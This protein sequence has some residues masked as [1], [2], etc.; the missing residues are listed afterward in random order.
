[1]AIINRIAAY[2]EDMR[3]WRHDIHR[4][5]ELAYEEHRTA[6]RVAELLREFGVDEVA[7]GIGKTG[8]VGVIRN[9]EG[10]AIGLRADMDA[11]PI[12][13]RTGV[14]HQSVND[15]VMR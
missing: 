10:P 1:M 2:V 6:G 11:L 15:G 3:A 8:V 14:P 9:G 7:E 5:P 4:H 12:V 13:E